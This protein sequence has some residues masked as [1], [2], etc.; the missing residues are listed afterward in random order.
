MRTRALFTV[1]ARKLQSGRRVFYYQTYNEKG[2]R[3]PLYSTGKKTKTAAAAYCMEL[4]RAGKLL[5]A[6][7]EMPTFAEFARGWWDYDTCPYLQKQKARGPVAK[8]SADVAAASTRN[9][10]IPMFG[11]TRLDGITATGVDDWLTGFKRRGFSNSTGNTAIKYLRV[12]LEEAKRRG[13][14]K[15]NPCAGVKSLPKETKDIKILAPEE[16]KAL[17]PAVW[18]GV[19]N[20]ETIYILNKLAACT[21]MRIGELLGL[22]GEYVFDG[23]ITVAGQ[24]TKYGYGDVKTRKPR[25]ITI[26]KTVERDLL[27][28]KEKNGGGYLFSNDGGN[29]PVSRSSVDTALFSAL[30][31]IGI[32]D[33]ERR[34]RKL[35]MHGWRHFLN[36]ALL[37]ANV[38]DDKVMS[39]TGHASKEMKRRYTHFDTTKFSEVVNVQEKLL[40]DNSN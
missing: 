11:N 16:E 24:Y 36:T 18:S 23:Y 10:L 17:F 34:K 20:D 8:G 31:K 3:T 33:G 12:M 2:V 32:N 39:I 26:P 21:G 30:E 1:F 22:R 19:W 14:I 38:P 9:H 13:I 40:A 28:L 27:R 15:T 7:D 6:K 4:Y 25:D 29:K 37:A 5:P 35:S